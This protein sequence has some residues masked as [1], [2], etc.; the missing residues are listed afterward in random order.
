VET[1]NQTDHLNKNLSPN[2]KVKEFVCRCCGE[3]GIELDLIFKLQMA[4]DLLPKGQVM[5]IDSGYRCK[6]HNK[7]V[8]GVEG[9]SHRKGLGVDIR[10][11][12][13]KDRFYLV[14]A[15]LN[16][17]FKRFG[18]GRNFIHCDLDES[19]D[20]NVMWNYY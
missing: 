18:D 17:G 11:T 12:N 5:V 8:G 7:K 13:S 9:S 4:R 14:V 3:E 10:C 19:K 1:E 15:L 2:F 6:K 20:Q 16:A